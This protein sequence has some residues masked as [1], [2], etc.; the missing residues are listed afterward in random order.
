MIDTLGKRI[1][2]EYDLWVSKSVA[3]ES[4]RTVCLALGPYRNLTTLTASLLF[5]HPRC[6]VLNHGGLRIFGDPR[7]DWIAH[8]D[9]ATF[10]RFLRYAVLI[11]AT[12][13]RGDHGGSILHSHAFDARH[14][15][16]TIF[17]RSGL[18]RV[19]TQIE[20]LFWKE[21][22]RTSMHLRAHRVDLADL[23][24]KEPRLRFLL[25]IRNPM[26]CARSNLA[27][28]HAHLYHGRAENLAVEEILDLILEEISWFKKAERTAPERFFHF[29]EYE[30]GRETLSRLARFLRLTPTAEQ[31]SGSTGDA[32][33]EGDESW[34]KNA[35][36]AC[37]LQSGYDH[38]DSLIS[39][40]RRRVE[41]KFSDFPAFADRLLRFAES[42]RPTLRRTG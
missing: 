26:D 34:L 25:P 21:S 31:P 7:I 36:E 33:E 2:K 30:L 16:R 32:P 40:F 39:H 10:E 9:R 42:G 6:Q 18:G 3:T 19:K 11:S 41:E 24:A 8:Y 28:G 29:F 27:T 22:L 23:L 37:V 13:K 15:T 38:P 20:S 14:R 17:E 1:K 4:V 35:A 12:G 5:L